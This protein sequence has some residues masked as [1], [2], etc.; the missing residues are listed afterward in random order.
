ML[1]LVA[2]LGSFPFSQTTV[3]GGVDEATVFIVDLSV[4][5]LNL[6]NMDELNF[7]LNVGAFTGSFMYKLPKRSP[8]LCSVR[9]SV[10][11]GAIVIFGTLGLVRFGLGLGFG[12]FLFGVKILLYA[13]GF[14]IFFKGING[15][16]GGK[17]G[18]NGGKSLPELPMIVF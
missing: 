18:G 3:S 12:L 10:K 6:L 8:I 11:Q 1:L 7:K 5:S 4:L 9:A 13:G 17:P 14:G 16:N 2:V 15:G